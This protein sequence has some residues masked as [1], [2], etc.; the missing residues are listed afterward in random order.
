MVALMTS[1]DRRL[2]LVLLRLAVF[3]VAMAVVIVEILTGWILGT[4]IVGAMVVST[5]LAWHATQRYW[6]RERGLRFGPV[7][8]AVALVFV[9]LV[10][11]G[12]WLL[13][14]YFP[15]SVWLS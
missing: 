9:W 6:R 12:L 1:I 14:F 2:T 5:P 8:M 3:V 11:C 4:A 13:V 10:F 15:A 7:G